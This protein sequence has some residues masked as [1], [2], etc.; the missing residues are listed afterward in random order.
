MLN[1]DIA[2][3]SALS[4]SMEAEELVRFLNDYSRG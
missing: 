3:F 4:Q 2:G 1:S